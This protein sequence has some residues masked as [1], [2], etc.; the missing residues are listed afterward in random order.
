MSDKEEL[1]PGRLRR[2]A[3]A[4]LRGR[5]PD[6]EGLAP[7]DLQDLVH[8]LQVHQIELELQNEALRETQQAL[9]LARDEYA[10]LYDG[11]PVG[12][13][14]V[15]EEGAIARVNATGAGLLAV[16][17]NTLVGQ[18]FHR[19]VAPGDQDAYHF[20]LLRLSE[21]DGPE[22]VE[23]DL[24]GATG[25]RFR[26]RIEGVA[27]KAG[28]NPRHRWRVVVSDVTVEYEAQQALQR[29]ADE[30]GALY[31]VAAALVTSLDPAEQ[32]GR[33]LGVLLRVFDA[34]IAWVTLAGEPSAGS[35]PV[36]ASRG[37]EIEAGA[38]G[39]H[40]ANCL[41]CADLLA[42]RVHA[43]TGPAAVVRCR[44]VPAGALAEAGLQSLVCLP[45][46]AREQILGVLTLAWRRQRASTDE[47]ETLLLAVG[48]QV[49]L[50]LRNAQLHQQ[51]RQVDRLEVLVGLDRA[52]S[53]SLDLETVA[54]VALEHVA[55][56]VGAEEAFLLPYAVWVH[57]PASQVL[58][59]GEGWI[60]LGDSEA[61]G[62]W[63]QPLATLGAKRRDVAEG[64]RAVSRSATPWGTELLAVPLDGRD[65]PLADLVLAGS[66]FGDDDVA[67]AQA[68]AGR[69]AQ[70]LRNAQLYGEVRDLLRQREETQALL[71]QNEKVAA[72]GRLTASLS[73]EINNPLQSVLG[74]LA[75][76]EEGLDPA[77]DND[78]VTPYLAVG[79]KEIQR[80]AAL[81]RRMREFYA[82]R[83]QEP[84][85]ADVEDVLSAVVDLTR[86]ELTKRDVAIEWQPS[87]RPQRV[88]MRPDQLQQ[89]FLNLLLNAAEA[90]PAGGTVTL[91]LD[92]DEMPR[93]EGGSAP[94]V[95]V[96]VQDGGEGI[97]PEVQQRLFE[98]FF[99]T[100]PEGSGLGL[101]VSHR[102]IR[103]HGGEIEIRSRDGEGTTVSVWLPASV[104]E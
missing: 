73:H 77:A 49:A 4:V 30:Q 7:K 98:P 91:R 32:A 65:G 40:L 15:D 2:Q 34:T 43:G 26:A 18:P 58:T 62:R 68:A 14:T 88:T 9:E 76:A 104:S 23:L 81:V 24:V 39:S 11:A 25:T 33:V 46:V 80:I 41:G 95:R 6:L 56:A 66:D 48:Q 10:A 3:E 37:I 87:G 69:A 53:A 12:Y 71:V 100:K 92:R 52:L 22:M 67:L 60:D 31:A 20:F 27:P 51:A 28:R 101:Y 13:F 8:E 78:A 90:M 75:L 36:L 79:I 102:I 96:D 57:G 29:Y 103:E 47:D 17:V 21:S 72:L 19:W 82:P 54:R 50:G 83:S 85:L 70:A 74:C 93:G 64:P 59:S 86:I 16:E 44:Q 84:I 45:L 97:S 94:A 99:T 1:R 35:W 61:H 38:L 42:G 55:A 63:Q 5:K 89:V